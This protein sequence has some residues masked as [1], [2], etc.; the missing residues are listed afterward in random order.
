MTLRFPRLAAGSRLLTFLLPLAASLPLGAQNGDRPNDPQ[1]PPPAHWD[2]PPAPALAVDE[3]LETFALAPGFR[4]EVIAAEPLIFDPVAMQIGP[5]GRIWVVEMRGY[6][7]NVDGEGEDAPIGTV[8]VLTDTDGDG[9]MD[10]RSEFSGGLVMPRALAL[11]DD[12]VLVAAPPMLWHFRDTD[13][14]EIADQRTV[15]SATYGSRES[16]EHT[17]NGL[18]HGLDNWIYNANDDERLRWHQGEWQHE[19][20]PDRGQW[21]IT[22]DDSGRLFY[23]TNSNPLKVDLFPGEYLLRNP[24]QHQHRAIN[25]ELIPNSDLRLFPSRITPGVNRG[26]KILDDEGYLRNMTAACGPVIYRGSLYPETFY[27]D[28]F[29]AEPAAHLIKRLKITPTADGGVTGSNAYDHFEF[30]TSTDERFRPVNL[31]NGPDGGLYVVDMYRGIIQHRIFVTSFLRAQIIERGLET[32]LGMGRIYRIVPDHTPPATAPTLNTASTSELVAALNRPDAWWR[33]TA[34]RL[35]VEQSD[36]GAA[37]ALRAV[38]Q[39]ATS[40]GRLNAV[41]TLHGIGELDENTLL[42]SLRDDAPAMRIAALQASEP[43]L[44]SP[45]QRIAEHVL[46]ALEA[47]EA[48]VRR[49]AVLSLGAWNHPDRLTVLARVAAHDDEVLA[50]DEALLSGIAGEELELLRRLPA[51]AFPAAQT[52]A[53]LAA[54]TV[55]KRNAPIEMAGLFDLLASAETDGPVAETLLASLE[56]FTRD[57]NNQRTRLDLSVEPTVLTELA[58][59]ASPP[60]AARIRELLAQIDGPAAQAARVAVVPLTDAEQLQFQQGKTVFA[61]CAGCHQTNGRGLPGLAPPLV[62]SPWAIGPA[63]IAAAIVLKGKEGAQL[64]MP[65]LESLDDASIAAALTFARRS[66]GHTASAV[67]AAEVAAAREKY[68]SRTSPWTEAD[69]AQLATSLT[70]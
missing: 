39:D 10:K 64:A 33:E 1:R 67:T 56:S 69:L 13:G 23:N 48:T 61:L 68:Q 18:M 2:I 43:Y 45:D 7:P 8:A 6:M 27:G 32:P 9:R 41:W 49:Q 47:P 31:Y 16:P 66:W 52:I 59:H 22:Q 54:T 35:L 4:I 34:Q 53:R 26:Y 46:A 15:V 19:P 11:V 12:G 62:G 29:I 37:P 51:D 30:L 14:D 58:T 24:D 65:P 55:I 5:D 38:W 28:A 21:G 44:A 57:R 20:S 60:H 36:S 42:A 50:M 70:P 3:A 63:E 17:A 40:P 25:R